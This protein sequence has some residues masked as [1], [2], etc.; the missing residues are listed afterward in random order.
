MN[1]LGSVGWNV[2]QGGEATAIRLFGIHYLIDRYVGGVLMSVA[3]YPRLAQLLAERRIT[4][5]EL[6]RQIQGRYG[7]AVNP[8][9]LYRLTQTA[10]IQHADLEIVSAAATILGVSLDD[11]F[12]V[13]AI[14]TDAHDEGESQI[15]G[16]VDSRRMAELVDRQAR[17]LLT[18][19]EWAEMEGLVGKYGLLLHERRLRERARRRGVS[20]DQERRETEAHLAHALD[21]WHAD[22][23]EA[24][25][26]ALVE[27]AAKQHVRSTTLRG[28]VPSATR[29]NG[30]A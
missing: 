25:Q 5:A 10:P 27:Q 13:D 3:V 24:R 22:E 19:P 2:A 30:N 8:K 15:L 29:A 6:G 14:A 4:V 23:V 17:R 12:T 11:L 9:T 28:A 21:N 20:L 7:L 16:P 18:E 26:Q 1:D